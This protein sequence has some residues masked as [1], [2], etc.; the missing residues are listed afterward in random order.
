MFKYPNLFLRLPVKPLLVPDHLEGDVLVGLVVV[1]LEDLAEGPLA[2]D[3]EDLVSVAYVVMGYVRVGAL[4]L[5]KNLGQ[6]TSAAYRAGEFN[7]RSNLL[8]ACLPK[9]IQTRQS[10]SAVEAPWQRFDRENK[11]YTPWRE[12]PDGR[13][14]Q[15]SI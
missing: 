6:D 5:K 10:H 14:I 11:S 15:Y 12:G 4:K 7:S 2:D 1:H 8:D 9:R 13:H 3:F